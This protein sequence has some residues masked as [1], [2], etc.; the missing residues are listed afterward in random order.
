MGFLHPELLILAVPIGFLW[1]RT[2]GHGVVTLVLRAVVALLLVLALAGPYLETEDKGRDLVVVVDRSRSMPPG[3]VDSAVELIELAEDERK[4]GDHVYVVS[5]GAGA[6]IEHATLGD[7]RFQGFGELVDADGSDLGSALETALNLVEKG[8]K[9]GILL[10]SDGEGNGVDPIPVAR[11]ALGRG[12]RVDVRPYARPGTADL[13]VER[14]DLPGE[15]AVG[16]PFQF[17][18]WVRADRQ[19]E[20]SF[21]L[22]RGDKVLS[23]GQRT[24]QPGLNRVVFRD[25]L[26]RTGV[27][28]YEVQLGAA[29]DRFPENNRGLGAVRATGAAALLVLNHDGSEDTLV[30]ALR[31]ARIPVAV[32]RPEDARLDP[33]GLS[34]FRGVI[35]ENVAAD[36][37]GRG[38]RALRDFVIDRGGGLM[39]T[40]GGASFGVGGYYL[41]PID[42]ILP[43]TMELRQEHRKM[44]VA[45]AVALDRSG[46]MSMPVAGNMTKMDLANRGTAEA[47]KLLSPMDSVAVIAVDS[48][49][50]LVQELTP[51]RD[52]NA[53]TGRVLKIES[54]G[55]GIFTFTAL[56]AARQQLEAAPQFNRHIILFADAMDSEEQDGCETLARRMRDE[57]NTTLSVIALGTETDIDADFLKRIAEVG[58]GE[59]HFSTDPAELPRLFAMDTM[60]MSRSTFIDTPTQVTTLPELFGVGSISLDSF[61]TLGGYN[62]TYLRPEA[63]AGIAT[64]DEYRAPVFAFMQQ[65]LGRTA[66]YTGQ[67]GGTY[68]A[69]FVEWDDFAEF[70]VTVGRWLMGLEEPEE[71]FTS[72]RREGRNAVITVEV[73]AR[74]PLPPDT[75][76][77]EAVLGAVDGKRTELVLERTGEYEFEARYPLDREGVAVGTVA[78]GNDRFVTL[79]PIVLPYSPEFE[80]TP[81]KDHGEKLLRRIARET[82][83]E[84]GAIAGNF[85]R[86]D[87]IGRLWKIITRE[88][89]LAALVLLLIEIAGRRLSLWG[90]IRVPEKLV[91]ASRRTVQRAKDKVA[92]RRQQRARRAPAREAPAEQE[93]APPTPDAPA[94]PIAKPKRR[95]AGGLGSAMSRARREANR[96]LDR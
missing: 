32:A 21:E 72:V 54:M 34:A 56:E 58:G 35:I 60:T 2:R 20:S 55:G 38:M 53:I 33:V 17:N 65:G 12:V 70:T 36:R 11:R 61:P 59:A 69:S 50:H 57:R 52:V 78:L 37:L 83:G 46:S 68:G 73:D 82:G 63:Q 30:A 88:L 85:F 48:A 84:V 40:G 3:S 29:D 26:E 18:V 94:T 89:M 93:Q 51:V 92:E 22:R 28:E 86:G 90:S 44:A 71:F 91:E 80:R 76:H 75:S 23:S 77:L 45:L 24:F 8:R 47:I 1:W 66:A 14:L 81:D 5:F 15:V 31:K 43:V 39:L 74:A 41:S 16:E 27:A 4:D 13:L 7:E 64:A 67:I 9:G 79:P 49:P 6:R 25:V 87:R 95:P 19:T 62:L 10:L 42:K 96:K